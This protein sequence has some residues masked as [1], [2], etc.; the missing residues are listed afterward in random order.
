MTMTIEQ[1]SEKMKDIDRDARD[2]HGGRRH[3]VAADE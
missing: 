3:R 2:A 1:L